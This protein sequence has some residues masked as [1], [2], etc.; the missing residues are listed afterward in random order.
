MNRNRVHG[1]TLVELLVVITIIGILIA[2]LLPAVQAARE[3]ARKMQC[4]NNLKQIGVAMHSLAAAHEAFPP[5]VQS[6]KPEWPYFLHFLLPYLEQEAYYVTLDGP[7]F[8]LVRPWESSLPGWDR[9]VPLNNV[10]IPGLLCPDDGLGTSFMLTTPTLRIPKSNYLGIFSGLNDQ[11]GMYSATYMPPSFTSQQAQDLSKRHAVF[12]YET[13]TPFAEITDG[14]SNTMAVAEY[15]KGIDEEDC[16]G[17]PW[18]NR[19]GLQMLF[20][21]LGPNSTGEDS[22]YP[23]FCP[24]EY[25]QPSLNLPCNGSGAIYGCAASRSRHPG[26]VNVVYCDGSTHF[27]QDHVDITVWQNLGWINDGNAVTSDF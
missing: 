22:L 6:R 27:I 25:N 19:G 23:S 2:L 12:R 11:E 7:K 24:A 20:V 13:G 21:K 9:W 17:A 4:S 14:T 18:S 15:L 1:F 16:R 3:A 8:S 10:S 26:G 5:G